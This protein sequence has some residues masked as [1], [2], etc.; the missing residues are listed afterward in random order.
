MRF[1]PIV[2]LV[3]WCLAVML[4]RDARAWTTNFAVPTEGFSSYSH[5]VTFDGAGD[6][7]VGGTFETLDGATDF[8]QTIKYDGTTGAQIWR[9]LLRG[10]QAAGN[11][12]TSFAANNVNAIAVDADDNPV[13][14]GR[15]TNVGGAGV[16]SFL[17]AKLHKADGHE[18]WR[19]EIAVAYGEATDV[20]VDGNGDVV[21]V[22]SFAESTSTTA[23]R[24][25]VVVK[26]AGATG[27]PI[28]RKEVVTATPTF[29]D[30]NDLAV[31]A[32]GS[33]GVV[34]HV[35]DTILAAKL[36]ADTG[37]TLWSTSFPG[38]HYP[39][40]AIDPSGYFYV[41]GSRGSS[42]SPRFGV[43]V[44]LDAATGVELWRK[45]LGQDGHRVTADAAGVVW[46]SFDRSGNFEGS[47]AVAAYAP[48]GTPLWQRVEASTYGSGFGD[49][50]LDPAGDVVAAVAGGVADQVLLELDR[51]S[52]API[53]RRL[54]GG[55]PL[56]LF[57]GSI[58]LDANGA[59]VAVASG[60][61]KRKSTPAF[62]DYDVTTFVVAPE[63]FGKGLELQNNALKPTKN[64]ASVQI[65]D[66]AFV[67]PSAGGPADPSIAG[68]T[69]TITNPTTNETFTTTLPAG[70]WTQKK[71]KYKYADKKP[72]E[73]P[74][75]QAAVVNGGWSVKCVGAGITFTLDEASQGVLSAVLQAQ[76]VSSCARFGGEVVKDLPAV[77]KKPG[78]FKAKGAP[79]APVCP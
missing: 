29:N 16:F 67:A 48:D 20:V 45:E 72:Y 12:F 15:S 58:A 23:L 14:A 18:L 27:Q 38:N 78:V 5:V 56:F 9:S 17:A 62:D 47:A 35:G 65:K 50:R 52:G 44:K 41:S 55:K 7:V 36:A 51:G 59:N 66:A 70:N 8:A 39:F 69:F 54:L 74:C 22:G 68:A 64:K 26:L 32:D 46:A 1:G 28:W 63:T 19:Y 49:V 60:S 2:A 77:D 30:P 79:P 10:T 13:I 53:S 61:R 34:S 57:S 4:A 75:I 25:R 71:G 40:L 6:V 37:D 33:I 3:T 43:L 21:V 73:G 42:G 24:R 11:G 76:T 31:A